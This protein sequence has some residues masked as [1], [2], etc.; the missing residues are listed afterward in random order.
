VSLRR[1]LLIVLVAVALLLITAILAFSTLLA[2]PDG[3]S[4]E[5][6]FPGRTITG[7]TP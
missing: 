6:R 3:D 1:I 5:G 7:P 4:G 2:H